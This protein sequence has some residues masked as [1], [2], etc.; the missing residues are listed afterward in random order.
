MHL[1]RWSNDLYKQKKRRGGR[2]EW[3]AKRERKKKKNPDYTSVFTWERV[4]E[5][6]F[7]TYI[8]CRHLKFIDKSRRDFAVCKTRYFQNVGTTVFRIYDSDIANRRWPKKTKYKRG[9]KKI[10]RSSKKIASR[11]SH[12]SSVELESLVARR[13][14]EY[15]SPAGSQPASQAR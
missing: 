10:S 2:E 4:C 5:P 13:V 6:A 9:R 11:V 3:D 1:N 14:R 8:S 12:N 7:Y 15:Y